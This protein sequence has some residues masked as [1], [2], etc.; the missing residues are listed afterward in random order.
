MCSTLF[1]HVY[2]VGHLT[3]QCRNPVCQPASNPPKSEPIEKNTIRGDGE[4]ATR[5]GE[6]VRRDRESARRDRETTRRDRVVTGE[7]RE[8]IIRRRD[9]AGG[10]RWREERERETHISYKHRGE[11]CEED[12]DCDRETRHRHTRRRDERGERREGHRCDRDERYIEDED[13]N[14][15]V[16]RRDHFDRGTM[17]QKHRR[18]SDTDGYGRE[19]KSHT[20]GSERHTI[21][22]PT[23][24]RQTTERQGTRR[25]RDGKKCVSR[26]RRRF[27]WSTTDESDVERHHKRRRN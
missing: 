23:T 19:K 3:Y 27:D 26:R 22:R 13:S 6:T 16:R 1:T 9:D 7:N 25:D 2:A 24:E 5:D 17:M 20:V 15:G 12:R 14:R 18:E 4:T 21:E 8:P 10:E 11:G